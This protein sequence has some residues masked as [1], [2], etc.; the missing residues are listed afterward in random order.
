MSIMQNRPSELLLTHY[1]KHKMAHCQH[2]AEKAS[3]ALTHKLSKAQS[4]PLSA[5][6]KKG[7]QGLTHILFKTQNSPLSVS[8]RKGLMDP[9]LHPVNTQSSPLSASWV[10]GQLYKLT[11]CL[12]PDHSIVSIVHGLLDPDL[13]P[14]QNP[15]QP[16]VSILQKR[17]SRP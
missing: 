9:D 13:H 16:Y 12:N 8:H 5:L 14:V 10:E 11:S 6:C 1:S 3:W 7:L 17:P 4:N 15:E 2:H